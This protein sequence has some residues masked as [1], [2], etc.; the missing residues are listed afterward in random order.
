MQAG[1]RPAWDPLHDPTRP[2][3][4]ATMIGCPALFNF[5]SRLACWG[6]AHSRI[7]CRSQRCTRTR[8]AP[9]PLTSS[10]GP[11]HPFTLATLSFASLRFFPRTTL[12]HRLADAC[13]CHSLSS[14]S[15]SQ[16]RTLPCQPVSRLDCANPVSSRHLLLPPFYSLCASVHPPCSSRLG[17]GPATVT[18]ELME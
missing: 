15:L 9:G 14:P 6:Q 2:A 12:L 8:R 16:S 3:S 18:T 4:V 7:M 10:S 17:S 5:T 1:P 11:H 13:C